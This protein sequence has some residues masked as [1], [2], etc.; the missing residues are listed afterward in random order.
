MKA[1]PGQNIVRY[2][3]G[4]LTATLIREGLLDEPQIWVHPVFYGKA[5]PADLISHHATEA[6]FRLA[7]VRRYDS[8]V[9]ILD[10]ELI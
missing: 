9:V 1:Q 8:G 4:P 3:Y 2:G 10:Y 6:K 5:G 7:D